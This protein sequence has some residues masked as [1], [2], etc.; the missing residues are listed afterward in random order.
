MKISGGQLEIG[1]QDR[2]DTLSPIGNIS[3]KAG[4]ADTLTTVK[5]PM[6]EEMEYGYPART[7]AFEI[8]ADNQFI[9]C[10]YLI[11]SDSSSLWSPKLSALLTISTMKAFLAEAT[12]SKT[13]FRFWIS[14]SVRNKETEQ[15]EE[16]IAKVFNTATFI[17]MESGMT[18][19]FSD[20]LAEVIDQYGEAALHEIQ[21]RILREDIP[22]T[23]AAESLRYIGNIES[24]RFVAERRDLLEAC[25][26]HSRFMLVRDGA[27][28]G[29]SYIE[30]PKSIPSLQR[31]IDH[32]PH[33][34]LKKDLIEVLSLLQDTS[35]E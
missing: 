34:E 10:N 15:I 7:S 6:P 17:D 2:T 23:I 3:W 1:L 19:D 35:A 24:P 5:Q 20:G 22:F 12:A 32:E 21:K 11:D 13:S 31:A 14:E 25:L 27:A 8:S 33:A 28:S 16:E 29:L 30:D 18:N 9:F 26:L 4:S